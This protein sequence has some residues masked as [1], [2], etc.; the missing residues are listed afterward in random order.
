MKLRHIAF[1]N[2]RRRWARAA[3]IFLGLA[4]GVTAMVALVGVSET[5]VDEVNHQLETYGA[6][7]LIM[8]KSNRLNLSY[9]GM[10]AGSF[11]FDTKELRQ[12]DLKAVATI[13]NAANVAAVGPVVLGPVRIRETDVLLA[14]I[15]FGVVSRIKPWWK[16]QGRPPGPAEVVLGSKAAEVLHLGVSDEVLLKG[17][18]F[19]V[20][21]LLTPSGSQDDHLVFAALPAAQDLLEKQGLLSMVEVAALCAGCPIEEMVAQLS[22]ALPNASVT[23]IQSVVRTR[24]EALR[25][26][27][28]FSL[29]G[30]VLVTVIGG[31]MVLVTTMASVRERRQEIGLFRALGFRRSH[32]VRLILL[33]TSVLAVGAGVFGFLA[34]LVLGW[35]LGPYL[36]GGGPHSLALSPLLAAAAVLLAMAVGLGSALYPALSAARLDPCDALRS[37]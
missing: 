18:A 28:R 31:L 26:F 4:V 1:S 8:P 14:G 11:S 5:M 12:D 16:I 9:G 3:F 37:L 23:A 35:L 27:R 13:K 6:N 10:D 7:I 2:L 30:A 24:M 15:D 21:G 34:G 22:S 19:R 20:S 29:A 32:I 36:W 33:E 25:I 17:R